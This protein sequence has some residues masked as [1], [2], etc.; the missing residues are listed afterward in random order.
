MNYADTNWLEEQHLLP[1]NG[2]AGVKRVQ[3]FLGGI[4]PTA[5]P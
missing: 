5:A 3:T 2:R 1:T 4:N